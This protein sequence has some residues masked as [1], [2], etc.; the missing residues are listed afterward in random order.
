MRARCRAIYVGAASRWTNTRDAAGANQR[1]R[2]RQLSIDQEH[3]AFSRWEQ[4]KRCIDSRRRQFSLNQLNLRFCLRPHEQ[5]QFKE[6]FRLSELM[7]KVP[8]SRVVTNST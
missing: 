2:R 3:V 7:P 5:L 8:F 4:L 1:K 6:I